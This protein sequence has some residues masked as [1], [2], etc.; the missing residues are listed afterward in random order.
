MIYM[1]DEEYWE[2]EFLLRGNTHLSPESVIVENIGVFKS[3]SILDIACGD[4]RNSLFFSK[5]NFK[6]TG[7][8]FSVEALKRL[9]RF[10]LKFGCDVITK[11]VNTGNENSLNDI[12]I[13]DNIV[14]S[15]YKF[16]YMNELKNHIKTDG[17]LLVTGFGHKHECDEKITKEDLIYKKDISILYGDF[18]LIDYIES[19]DDRGCFSTYILRKK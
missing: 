5:N 19:D 1:G 12:G 17:I 16:R 14:I 11:E 13:Y 6:V 9:D 4:G 15:H 18:D 10:S 3:G 2:N 8:D 7:I